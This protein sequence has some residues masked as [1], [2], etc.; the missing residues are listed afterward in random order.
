MARLEDEFRHLLIRGASPLAAE[1]LQAS[2]LRRL[3]LTV[4]SF[5]SSAVDLDCPSFAN[6]AGE[7]GDEPA[8]RSSVSDDEI[9]PYLIAP[10]TVGA[11][12]D[13]ADVMLRAGYAPELC[14]VY[15]RCAGT[16]SW[17]ASPCLGST[18]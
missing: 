14:Q 16:R 4:P 9:S 7:G 12:R 3:S 1:D 18:G 6:H 17:S 15:G 8:G 2:L 10:D 13:I 5:N 11:L